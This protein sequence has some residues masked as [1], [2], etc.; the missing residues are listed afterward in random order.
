MRDWPHF[1]EGEAGPSWLCSAASPSGGLTRAA[2]G[3]MT[4]NQARQISDPLERQ[5]VALGQIEAARETLKAQARDWSLV[6][7]EAVLDS[8]GAAPGRRS[9]SCSG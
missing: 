1:A 6:R 4:P 2:A 8:R 7:A 9:P 3:T 5:Q